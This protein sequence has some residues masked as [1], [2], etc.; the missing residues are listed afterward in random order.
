MKKLS[1]LALASGLMFLPAAPA[2]AVETPPPL[3]EYM[4]DDNDAQWDKVQEWIEKWTA[5]GNTTSTPAPTTPAPSTP[6]PSTGIESG[7]V[8]WTETGATFEGKIAGTSPGDRVQIRVDT[9][10]LTG[11]RGYYEYEFVRADGTVKFTLADYTTPQKTLYWHIARGGTETAYGDVVASGKVTQ[12]AQPAPSTSPTTTAPP[13]S[14]PSPTTAPTAP[15][16]KNVIGGSYTSQGLTSKYH[17][18]TEGLDWSK[19]V[20]LI[21]YGDGSGGYGIDNPTSSYLLAG[22]NGLVAVAK[23]HNMVLLTP[24]A[25]GPSTAPEC[26]G[27]DNCWYDSTGMKKAAWAGDL[28]RKVQ[29]DLP[30]AKD[31]VAIGGY[32]SGAEFTSI[33]FG[34]SQAQSVMTDGVMVPISYGGAPYTNPTFSQA[35][36]DNVV[37]SWDV[38]ANDTAA[39]RDARAGEA[40][41]KAR[42]FTTQLNVVANKGHN[43]NNGEFGIIMDREIT[44]HVKPSK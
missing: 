2:A 5:A 39:L 22:E 11:Q 27:T 23:K 7:E 25:P 20:G 1:A 34:P 40:W 21:V 10:E 12:P 6:A 24:E 37:V 36:K 35:F 8:K 17:L 31:R 43:R 32:S 30:I 41:Y 28:T 44:E 3:A 15:T 14:S 38:G 42:G 33:F 9:K 18:Y 29:A 19:P 4:D 26:E 13:T 16:T